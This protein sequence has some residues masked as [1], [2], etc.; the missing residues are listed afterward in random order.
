M[1][2][3]ATATSTVKGAMACAEDEEGVVS[4]SSWVTVEA[5]MLWCLDFYACN[6]EITRK[7]A[8]SI[9]LGLRGSQRGVPLIMT[10]RTAPQ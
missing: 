10:K 5:R 1:V 7:L 8:K 2:A 4:A 6:H 3:A 9:A